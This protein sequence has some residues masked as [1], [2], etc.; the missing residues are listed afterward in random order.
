[1]SGRMLTAMVS[2]ASLSYFA[3]GFALYGKRRVAMPEKVAQVAVS[4]EAFLTRLVGVRWRSVQYPSGQDNARLQRGGSAES[5]AENVDVF[6]GTG[7]HG[8]TFPGA[9]VPWGMVYATPW[10]HG[11]VDSWDTQSGYNSDAAELDFYGMAHTALSGAG[12]GELGELRLLPVASESEEGVPGQVRIYTGSSTGS[13][14]YFHG[15]LGMEGKRFCS[16]DSTASP[17]GAMHRF[18]FEPGFKRRSVKLLLSE[19]PGGFWGYVLQSSKVS[20]PSDTELEGCAY[21]QN[22]GIG[23]AE[24]YLC[25]VIQ[26]D[27]AF[28]VAGATPLP[29]EALASDGQLLLDFPDSLT[30]TITARV[31][32]SRTDIGRARDSLERELAGRSF[33][34]VVASAQL[35][36]QKA[37]EKIQVKIEPEERSRVFYTAMYHMMMA[38][39]LISDEDGAYRLQRSSATLSQRGESMYDIEQIDTMMPIQYSHKGAMY[40]TFSFWDTYRGLHPLL[41]LIQPDVSEDF[42]S[43]LMS[44]VDTWGFLGNF[45]LTASPADIME[46]DGGSIILGTMAREGLV[47]KS[48]AFAS[49]K[50]SRTARVDDRESLD[51]QGYYSTFNGGSVSSALEEAAADSCASRLANDLGL[52]EDAAF[53]KKRADS[54]FLFWDSAEGLFAPIASLASDGAHHGQLESETALLPEYFTEGTA[55]QYAFAAEFDTEQMIAKHGGE[56]NFVERLDYFFNEAPENSGRADL[57]TGNRH[58]LGLGNEVTMHTPYLY[59]LAGQPWKSQALIDELVK[60]MFTDRPD[61]LPGN[62]D[63]GQM[64]AWV[65]LSMLG[66]YPVDACSGDFVLG[67]PFVSE[68]EV[69]VKNGLFRIKVHNQKDDNKYVDAVRWKGSSLDM[70]R[71]TL[72]FLEISE[73]G[74]LEFWMTASRPKG[75][76][77]HK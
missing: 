68:A 7:S 72:S 75:A 5:A 11:Q 10:G 20:A 51:E 19:A 61:G 37:L 60:D 69:Q 26:F 29:G 4:N 22:E 9:A 63:M 39:N 21:S 66:L 56:Q 1:M 47:D 71:P 52:T 35:L 38:P 41:N 15:Q 58:G 49:I 57:A 28:Q 40:S 76:S 34:D 23:G 24:S 6:L 62:D 54:A 8:H 14:G 55:L 17:R 64:S 53:F 74:T 42:A 12:A 18:S 50:K 27:S 32:V 3:A 2:V 33:E 43:S 48:A 31:G 65:A 45:Q 67:R 36:W 46:G 13:P 25:F 30:E 70:T 59:S 44:F 73:G 16:I 77:Q